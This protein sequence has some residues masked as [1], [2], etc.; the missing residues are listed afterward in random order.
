M[1]ATKQSMLRNFEKVQCEH[2]TNSPCELLCV[3]GHVCS[4]HGPECSGSNDCDCPTFNLESNDDDFDEDEEVER[5]AIG[6]E[7]EQISEL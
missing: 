3:C 4:E 2:G 5:A 1:G 6:A 7:E